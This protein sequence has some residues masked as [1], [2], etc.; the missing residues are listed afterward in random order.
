MTTA[1]TV[2]AT[3]RAPRAGS[4]R[5]ASIDIFRGLTMV[6]MIFVNELAGVRGLS[7]WTY[8]MPANVDAMT[9][10]DMVY[11]FFLFIVGLSLP[12]AIRHRLKK[13][14]SAP[15]LWLHVILRSFSLVVLGL[16]LA[17]ADKGDPARM[18]ISRS[19]WALLALTGG[20][21]VW[22]VYPGL[23]R[24]PVVVRILRFTGLLLMAAML[25]IFRRTTHDGHAA[26]IDFSYPE[27]LGLIGF[28]YFAVAILYIPTRRWLWAPLAWFIA[29]V[30]FNSVSVAKWIG[31]PSRAPLYLWP[32]G[33]GSWVSITMAGVVA[34]TIF[35]G[36][37]RWQSHRQKTL[38][39]VIFGI[40]CF[41]AGW[42]LTPLGIS[43]IRATPTWCL[44]SVG[45]ATV[46]F[47]LL[48]WI[49]DVKK[50]TRWAIFARPA[51]ANTLMTYLLPDFYAFFVALT[52][53]SYFETHFSAG[54]PGV[55]KSVIFTAFILGI[56]AILTKLKVRM[57][58]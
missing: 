45:A 25:I 42:L 11:P 5:V 9:Y 44:Y 51:G 38:L 23:E 52:G 22:N 43:K 17:N 50:Q 39:A 32:F 15:A 14:G 48:H 27:I 40:A 57:H 46:S 19:V 18:G 30:A 6:V 21:L 36:A 20:V 7:R 58:L 1:A 53:L 24:R 47:A 13:S 54:W 16:I 3:E 10:V 31:F 49:S 35:L 2:P 8:H 12:L 26:W 56:A 28:T 29:L 33:N 55:F 4:V 37:H 41:A 34:S